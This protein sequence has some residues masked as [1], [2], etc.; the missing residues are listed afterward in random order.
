MKKLLLFI[1]LVV[2]SL[3]GELPPQVYKELQEN[4]PEVVTL[5]ILNVDSKAITSDQR[6]ITLKAKVLNILRTQ[7]ALRLGSIVTIRYITTIHP[8]NW[9]GPSPLPILSKKYKYKAF[10]TH[11]EANKY[12]VPSA[13]GRSFIWL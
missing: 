3:Y 7:S 2:Y 8:D 1:L 6:E 13:R 9:V 10:L 4:S 11:D 12:Y 5:R